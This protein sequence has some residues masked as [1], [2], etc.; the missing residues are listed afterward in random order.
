M[1]A[2]MAAFERPPALRLMTTT[3]PTKTTSTALTSREY[4]VDD[5]GHLE[6]DESVLLDHPFQLQVM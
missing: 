3:D 2:P 4:V 6:H 1:R 5:A